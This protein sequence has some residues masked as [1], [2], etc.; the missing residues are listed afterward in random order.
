MSTRIERDRADVKQYMPD[1][2][3]QVSLDGR[4]IY[5][6]GKNTAVNVPFRIAI[7]YDQDERGYC[8]QLVGPALK[9]EW[10]TAH[11]G[12]IFKN[13]LIC[14]G[15]DSMK[16]R[17]TLREAYAKS[18]LWAE[19]MAVMIQSA[20]LGEPTHFPFSINSKEVDAL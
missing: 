8:A 3:Q 5:V 12:H 15:E 18:C 10:M 14:F 11:Q 20:L 16:T 9:P 6:F 2:T 7:Y 17:K 4:E 19:G 13:G 1:N